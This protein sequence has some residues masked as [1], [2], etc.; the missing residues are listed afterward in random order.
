MV[1]SEHLRAQRLVQERGRLQAPDGSCG[2]YLGGVENLSFSP[3]PRGRPGSDGCI[4][5]CCLT[6]SVSDVCS[7][8]LETCVLGQVLQLRSPSHCS[9]S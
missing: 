9:C 5:V 3:Q 6:V 7:A 4:T 1:H 8:D 2:C